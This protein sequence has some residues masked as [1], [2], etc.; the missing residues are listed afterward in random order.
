MVI[1]VPETFIAIVIKCCVETR[2]ICGCNISYFNIVGGGGGSDGDGLGV[3][4]LVN[5][6]V[7]MQNIVV[8]VVITAI[9]VVIVI[10]ALFVNVNNI[11]C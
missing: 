1:H 6:L 11:F 3:I 5:V 9:V 7:I 8:F 2:C 4:N 10:V